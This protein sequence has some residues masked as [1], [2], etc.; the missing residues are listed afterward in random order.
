MI[1]VSEYVEFL[2]ATDGMTIE[3]DTSKYFRYRPFIGEVLYACHLLGVSRTFF[4]DGEKAVYIHSH[5]KELKG[6]IAKFS[7]DRY[8][9]DRSQQT[10]G[11]SKK[12]LD[13]LWELGS[14]IGKSNSDMLPGTIPTLM[15]MMA[16]T[17]H[18]NK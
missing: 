15:L 2:D 6:K 12:Q 9:D 3:Q 17:E 11:L 14:I 13:A 5:S 4:M 7:I 16:H 1:E 10:F 8:V 18:V